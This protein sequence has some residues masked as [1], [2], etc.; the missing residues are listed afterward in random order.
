[1]SEVFWLRSETK[2]NEFRRALDPSA[3][4]KL[5]A[6]GHQVV[7]EDW[8][9]SI[10]P[11]KAYKK[12]GCEIAGAGSW[13]NS[14]KRTIIVGLKALPES[15]EIFHHRLI[16]F[17]H[18]YNKQ[19]GWENLMKKFSTAG[20]KIIDL[21]FMV[22]DKGRRVCAFGYWAG[23]VGASLGVLFSLTENIEKATQALIE[24][25]YFKEKSE[26][27]S[28]I[29]QFSQHFPVNKKAIVIGALGRSGNGAIDSLAELGWSSTAWDRNETESGG[30]FVDILAHD[31]FVNCV[32]AMKKMPP[33]I[34][35]DLLNSQKSDLKVIS[36]VSCDPDS[37]CNMVPLY[38]VATT[39][40]K[41][42]HNIK[43]E[44][45]EIK[46]TA[47]DNLPSI[48]PKESS[49]DFSQQLVGYLINFQEQNGPIK[50]ALD[51]FY[52]TESKL[53]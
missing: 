50:N 38:E 6:N 44:L 40:E 21:E 49:E 41:P 37:D 18:V 8:A 25:K 29:T 2:E 46:L 19:E 17:A 36:D 39:I 34:N 7:V 43:F 15:C 28:F 42:Y 3:C 33:F 23:Y 45:G 5:I 10:I 24:K 30:P 47:I 4:E 53:D 26:L 14:P 9:D 35:I 27:I 13:V 52:K 22:D 11:T 1:M 31:L 51:V 20:G 16:F 12:A 32:L 48:L